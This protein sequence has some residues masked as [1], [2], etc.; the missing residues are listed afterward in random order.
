M[1][2]EQSTDIIL[3]LLY[4][5]LSADEETAARAS[6]AKDP[7]LAAELAAFE[8]LRGQM[9]EFL[10]PEIPRMSVRESLLAEASK[11]A[12]RKSP[13]EN[14]PSRRPNSDGVESLGFWRRLGKGKASQL[15]L[16]ATVLLT[17]V[18][19]MRSGAMNSDMSMAPEMYEPSPST[20]LAMVAEEAAMPA[21]P[22]EP[23][24]VADEATGEGADG[25]SAGLA[26]IADT[27]K[28][29]APAERKRQ[30]LEKSVAQKPR[31]AS[32]SSARGQAS[33][34]DQRRDSNFA[35]DKKS[36]LDDS[37]NTL[38]TGNAS[39]TAAPKQS[40]TRDAKPSARPA[41]FAEAAPAA[42]RMEEAPAKDAYVSAPGSLDAVEDAFS[43]RDWRQVVQSSDA[44]LEGGG[45]SVQKA[46]ALELKALA[47][48][49]MGM[50]Q[51]A[52]NV[53]KNIEA[54]YSGYQPDRI[55]PARNEMERRLNSKP[56]PS[57]ARK[58]K[59]SVDFED[60]SLE[61]K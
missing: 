14:A 21:S 20:E 50:V 10:A 32:K 16:V 9:G 28:A 3:D 19:V 24:A 53:Y 41:E 48:Q 39:N 25:V 4:G 45:T 52:L 59:S 54:N 13:G 18:F 36:K 49:Q 57:P 1:A 27:A 8:S 58:A 5:E 7:A 31:P 15:A 42:E 6:V 29:E 47:Y 33:D 37:L 44:V 34:A 22:S 61:S 55:R 30:T 38:S 46:R 56:D 51:Q 43:A 40:Q 26:E 23:A 60:S 12:S 2:S 11:Q 35:Y 17:G